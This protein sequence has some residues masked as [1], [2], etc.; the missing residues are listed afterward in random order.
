MYSG[1]VLELLKQP[2][3]SRRGA[4]CSRCRVTQWQTMAAPFSEL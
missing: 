1:R 3:G 4:L 2:M